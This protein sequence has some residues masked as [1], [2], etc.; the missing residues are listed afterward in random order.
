MVRDLQAKED[1]DAMYGILL[2][3]VSKSLILFEDCSIQHASRLGNE[4]AHRL[5]RVACNVESLMM[6]CDC[7]P[8]FIFQAIWLDKCL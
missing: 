6:R 7:I 5:T 2:R 8:D 1:S 3:E 4:V